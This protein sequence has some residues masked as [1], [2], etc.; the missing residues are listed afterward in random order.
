[1]DSYN[2]PRTLPGV[3]GVI[4]TGLIFFAGANCLDRA[5]AQPDNRPPEATNQSSPGNKD[6]TTPPADKS[7]QE[8]DKNTE[9]PSVKES[10]SKDIITLDEGE[11]VYLKE[12]RIEINAIIANPNMPLEFFACTEGGKDYESLV[13]LKCKPH[14]IHMALLLFGLKEGKGPTAFGDASKPTGELALIFLEWQVKDKTVTYRGED[15]ILDERTQK[16]WPRVGWVFTGSRFEDELDYDTGKPTGRKLYVA[17]MTKTIIATYHDPAAILDNPT[18]S[19]GIGNIYYPNKEL[20][21]ESGTP[22]KVIIRLPD[23]KEKEELKRVNEEV[24]RW[25]DELE[26]QDKK[27]GK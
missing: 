7:P 14:N 20:L 6:K 13:V 19:G 17:D 9:S 2:K 23:N 3:I 11:K 5:G 10:E 24:A 27:D 18:R 8:P 22:C 12:K 26:K 4:I 25:E 1:M 15:L 21:P 16:P